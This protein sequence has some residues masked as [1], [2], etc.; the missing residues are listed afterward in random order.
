MVYVCDFVQPKNP[1][2]F[3]F[4]MES[5]NLDKSYKSKVFFS[6]K[7]YPNKKHHPKTTTT[8]TTTTT[9]KHSKTKPVVLTTTSKLF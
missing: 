1:R 3:Q 8:T 9:T 7:I 5:T 6:S 2:F 4:D